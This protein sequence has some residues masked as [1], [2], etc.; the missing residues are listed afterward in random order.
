[1]DL[2]NLNDEYEVTYVE[3]PLLV[4]RRHKPIVDAK[5]RSR[6]GCQNVLTVATPFETRGV[7]RS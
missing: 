4:F 6:C 3:V 2:N 5:S 7:R 1:M